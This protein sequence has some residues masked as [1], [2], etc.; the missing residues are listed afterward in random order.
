MYEGKSLEKE[1]ELIYD[2]NRDEDRGI[3][4]LLSILPCIVN[5]HGRQQKNSLEIK[6]IKSKSYSKDSERIV[7]NR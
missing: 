2:F 1:K 4:Q 6:E 7:K 5:C 3:R